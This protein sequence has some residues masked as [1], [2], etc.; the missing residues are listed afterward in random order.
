MSRRIFQ[1]SFG[2][3]VGMGARLL[4]AGP[5]SASLLLAAVLSLAGAISGGMMAEH[6]LPSDAVRPG[7]FVV[8]ALGAIAMLLI[9]G[10]AVQ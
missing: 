1:T 7:G 5:H 4:L 3:A 10:V 2:L 8:S 9:Y 6:L